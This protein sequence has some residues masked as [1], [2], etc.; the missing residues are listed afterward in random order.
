MAFIKFL[1]AA[2][3]SE[4][5]GPLWLNKIGFVYEIEMPCKPGVCRAYLF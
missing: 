4:S 5:A 2:M 1:S 3:E